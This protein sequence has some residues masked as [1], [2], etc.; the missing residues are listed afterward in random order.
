M[1]IECSARCG[2]LYHCPLL[3]TAYHS[4]IASENPQIR[5]TIDIW[6]HATPKTA[7]PCRRTPLQA[8]AECGQVKFLLGSLSCHPNKILSLCQ[9]ASCL[10]VH[11]L[12]MYSFM[13]VYRTCFR[14]VTSEEGFWGRDSVAIGCVSFSFLAINCAQ[15][16]LMRSHIFHVVT[17]FDNAFVNFVSF[18][19]ASVH[20]TLLWPQLRQNR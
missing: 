3:D 11:L 18:P 8:K 7:K 10:F 4:M 5:G 9:A 2:A 13:L 19:L 12:K 16:D 15:I 6:E 20:S 1:R 17:R 14:R